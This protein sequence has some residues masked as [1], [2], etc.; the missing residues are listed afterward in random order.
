[1]NEHARHGTLWAVV[2]V[3]SCQEGR[4]RTDIRIGIRIKDLGIIISSKKKKKKQGRIMGWAWMDRCYRVNSTLGR[5]RRSVQKK[6][7]KGSSQVT[8]T[9]WMAVRD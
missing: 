6:K 4:I 5:R 8:M 7:G 2:R 3:S 9:E 1:M